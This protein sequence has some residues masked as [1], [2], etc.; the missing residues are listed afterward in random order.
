MLKLPLKRKKGRPRAGA[1]AQCVD[2]DP[3]TRRHPA[4]CPA[5]AKARQR[6]SR[7]ERRRQHWCNDAFRR[8]QRPAFNPV[9]IPASRSNSTA[10][11]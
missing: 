10:H 8:W 6:R 9:D 7:A 1:T 3:A 4:R 5:C 2:L 11:N